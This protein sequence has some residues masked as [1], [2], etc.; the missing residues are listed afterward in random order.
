MAEPTEPRT[1]VKTHIIVDK[2]VVC[3]FSFC[4]MEITNSGRK[5]KH[6]T[7]FNKKLKLTNARIIEVAR[8]L[9]EITELNDD[10]ICVKCFR[11]VQGITKQEE[12]CKQNKEA[13][14]TTFKSNISYHDKSVKRLLRTPD[15]TKPMKKVFSP[16]VQI[17]KKTIIKSADDLQSRQTVRLTLLLFHNNS[18]LYSFYNL[19][20]LNAFQTHS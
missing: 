20:M 10:G 12:Q 16:K 1:P 2:C 3:S 19:K 5:L 11:K 8:I 18:V 9:P 6:D 4:N 17:W 15:S 14:R 7:N 13:V